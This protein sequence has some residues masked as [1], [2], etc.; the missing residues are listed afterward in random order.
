MEI[1]PIRALLHIQ[2]ETGKEGSKNQATPA[3]K[4]QAPVEAGIN[5]EKLV[6]DLLDWEIV[7]PLQTL[8][9]ALGAIQKKIKKH[10]TKAQ[11]PVEVG[12]KVHFQDSEEIIPAAKM[13]RTVPIPTI[14]GSPLSR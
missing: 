13:S 5:F 2:E 8:A 3:Y 9:G 6:E 1:A 4:S 10:M 11:L 12:P 7:I 14:S